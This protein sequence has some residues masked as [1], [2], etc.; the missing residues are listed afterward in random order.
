MRIRSIKP[1]FWRSADTADLDMFTRLLFIGLWNYVDDNGVGED[2]VSLIRSDLFPRDKNVDE[3]SGLIHGALI[4]LSRRSQIKRYLALESGRRYLCVAAWH[5][6]RINRPTESKKPLPTSEDTFFNEPS[7]TPHGGFTEPSPPDQGN[8]GSRE[9]GNEGAGEGAQPRS[10]TFSEQIRGSRDEAP[11]PPPIDA[12][13]VP[14]SATP[15]EQLVR[16]NVS[17]NRYDASTL[18]ALRLKTGELLNGGT[19]PAL[20]AETLRLWDGRDGGVGLIP[21]LLAD[22]AKAMNPIP[23][24]ANVTAFD[25]KKAHN[26]TVFQSLGEQPNNPELLA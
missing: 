22:A 19:D 25:R 5:H 8:E 10:R 26:A 13:I 14:R 11:Q 2:D 21:H 12:E 17:P 4:E 24:R 7:R 15:A 6:Q 3:L 18:T 9:Q 16:E 1:E 23:G 20:M